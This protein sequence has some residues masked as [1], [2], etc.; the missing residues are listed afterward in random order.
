MQD[1]KLENGK[2]IYLKVASLVNE[3][4]AELIGE[5][6]YSSVGAVVGATYPKQLQEIRAEMPNGY[7]LI[8]GYGA[9]GGK[10]EDIACLLYTSL[11]LSIARSL[12]ELQEGKFDI[13]L[14]GDLFKVVLKFK[15][16]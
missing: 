6:G 12:T 16:A 1:L 4:G 8:P 15:K 14:D 2:E 9:Q 13:Y 10:A 3:W 5:Y 7:F 11:G